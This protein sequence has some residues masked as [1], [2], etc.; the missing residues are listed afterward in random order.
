M[1]VLHFIQTT[2]GDTVAAAFFRDLAKAAVA[3]GETVYAVTADRSSG[4]HDAVPGLKAW[5]LKGSSHPREDRL[6]IARAVEETH[7]DIIHI[8]SMW[9]AAAREAYRTAKRLR[10]PFVVSTHKELMEWN[11][12][13]RRFSRKLPAQMLF[14]RAMLRDA[15][16]LHLVSEQE[17]QRIKDAPS[18][19]G[20]DNARQA[21][22]KCVVIPRDRAGQG[23]AP[24]MMRRLYR[25]VA[26][27]NP[28]MLMTAGEREA[29]NLLLAYGVAL[30]AA[31]DGKGIFISGETARQCLDGLSAE[32]WRRIQLHADTQG[33]QQPVARAMARLQPE[34]GMIDTQA[35]ERFGKPRELPFLE[36]ARAAIRV[37]RAKQMCEDYL[38]YGEEKKI[39]IMALNMKHLIDTG[40]VSR[41]NMADFY[42]EVR[43]ARYNE[44]KLEEMLDDIGMVKHFR[45]MV[46]VLQRSMLLEEGFTP[47]EPLHD[48]AARKTER[49]LF[50][51]NVQ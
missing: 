34:R 2:E 37:A 48:R 47:I 20:A 35:V 22:E 15:A 13:Y 11:I 6:T 24:E 18:L 28:F 51:A 7:P 45:R 1:K 41:R 17:R 25:K 27:S 33:V 36:T 4:I 31:E 19:T 42:Q 50:K 38:H 10:I 8:H 43:F 21:E 46:A 9:S 49:K 23:Q 26:D 12:S 5:R 30:N 3:D 16:A 14:Q 32:G 44:Y 39:C 29:E 40:K